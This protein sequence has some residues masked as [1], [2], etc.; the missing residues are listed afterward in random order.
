MRICLLT[1]LLVAPLFAAEPGYTD[2]ALTAEHR[3]HWSFVPVQRPKVPEKTDAKRIVDS[4][5]DGVLI[6]R[7]FLLMLSELSLQP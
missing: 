6:L 4:L 3:A 5:D 1:I 2:P 7:L